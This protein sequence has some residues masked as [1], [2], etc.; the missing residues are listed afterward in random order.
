MV[1]AVARLPEPLVRTFVVYVRALNRRTSCDLSWKVR[2]PE[3][4][5]LAIVDDLALADANLDTGT[6]LEILG[7]PTIR[8]L[9]AGIYPDIRMPVLAGLAV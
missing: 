1:R 9:D 4:D 7:D 8:S 3:V 2:A 6:N 5:H